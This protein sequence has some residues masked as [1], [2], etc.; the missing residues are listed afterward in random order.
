MDYDIPKSLI[1]NGPSGKTECNLVE[2]NGD[3]YQKPRFLNILDEKVRIKQTFKIG[4]TGAK[5]NVGT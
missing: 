5:R 1:Q 3:L 2:E 4:K